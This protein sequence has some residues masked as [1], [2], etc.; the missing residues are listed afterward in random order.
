MIFITEVDTHILFHCIPLVEAT[1]G[2]GLY[3]TN[4]KA[5]ELFD[6]AKCFNNAAMLYQKSKH[7]VFP[8]NEVV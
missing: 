1:C 6:M 8:T 5:E 2:L 4:N 7:L 3:V